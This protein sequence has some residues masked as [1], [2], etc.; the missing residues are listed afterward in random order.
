MA[1]NFA[2]STLDGKMTH[3]LEGKRVFRRR[4]I[5]DAYPE[6]RLLPFAGIGR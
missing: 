4:D 6:K 3:L 2:E 1:Q 5:P